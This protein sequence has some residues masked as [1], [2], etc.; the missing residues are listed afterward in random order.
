MSENFMWFGVVVIVLFIAFSAVIGIA[1]ALHIE[2]QTCTVESKDRTSKSDGKSD[3]RVYTEDCG[4]LKVG[5]SLTQ[6]HFNS[7]DTYSQ[8]KVGQRYDFKTQGYRIPVLSEFPNII[9]AT[10]VPAG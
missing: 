4:V 3:A 9:E 8:I 10:P 5:D 2:H 6:G 7:A 1:S